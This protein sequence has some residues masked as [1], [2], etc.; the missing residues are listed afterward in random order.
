MAYRNQSEI[1]RRGESDISSAMRIGKACWAIDDETALA[2]KTRDIRIIAVLVKGTGDIYITST[3]NYFNRDLINFQ[4][5]SARGGS[6][7]RLLPLHKF[8]VEYGK[9]KL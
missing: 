8:H 6:R 4:D 2:V 7:Q 1:Y 3:A 9:V 5:Y